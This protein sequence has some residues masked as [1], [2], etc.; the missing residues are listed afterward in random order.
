[1][2][3]ELITTKEENDSNL[4][5]KRR[6]RNYNKPGRRQALLEI[7]RL[8][9]EEG[10]SHNEIQLKLNLKPATYFRYINLLFKTEQEAIEG[11]NQ[12]YKRLLSETMILNQR[13][14][15]RAK[16]LERMADDKSIDAETRFQA[17]IEAAEFERAVHD[18]SYYAPSFLLAQGLIPEPKK[19]D[20]V[21]S[22][23]RFNHKEGA[24]E[25]DPFDKVRIVMASLIRMQNNVEGVL[26]ELKERN[27]KK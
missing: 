9:I 26:R 16:R 8:I 14:L 20:A 10:L 23:T 22:M 17:E 18:M 11:N 12:T 27:S 5:E 19:H 3:E 25:E 13:Y 6:P 24:E 4:I 2:A 15:R 1:L 21:L 7:R